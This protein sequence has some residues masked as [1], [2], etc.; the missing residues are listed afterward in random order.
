M[1]EKEITK[2]KE[3]L[4]D[5]NNDL[6]IAM[7]QPEKEIPI[8]NLPWWSEELHKAHLL[9]KYLKIR[10]KY[11]W[12]GKPFHPEILK[13]EIELVDIDVYQGNTNW[14]MTTQLRKAKKNRQRIRNNGYEIRRQFQERLESELITKGKEGSRKRIKRI[15]KEESCR[16]M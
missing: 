12:R 11:T 15:R 4:T 7:L 8:R 1:K 6:G 13:R 9:A 10:R 5:I 3:E 16:R 2:I 14:M